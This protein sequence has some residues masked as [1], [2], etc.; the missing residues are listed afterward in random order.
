MKIYKNYNNRYISAKIQMMENNI[1]FDDIFKEK[2]GNNNKKKSRKENDC[3]EPICN[4]EDP[5]MKYRKY[6]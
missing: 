5:L 3:F 1:E 6:N 4:K 2:E